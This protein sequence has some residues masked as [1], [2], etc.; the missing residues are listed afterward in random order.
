MNRE[1]YLAQ[2]QE[3]VDQALSELY[4]RQFHGT[5]SFRPKNDLKF[6]LT[7]PFKYTNYRTIRKCK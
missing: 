1:K 2:R 3:L 6:F 4:G 5:F 7:T